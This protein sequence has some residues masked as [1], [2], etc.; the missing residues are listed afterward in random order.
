MAR[1]VD[2]TVHSLIR[3][4]AQKC[5]VDPAAAT[6]MATDLPGVM[7]R[8]GRAVSLSAWWVPPALDLEPGRR[9]R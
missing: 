6:A 2:P 9:L 4:I 1:G 7:A 5:K 8:G 3:Q